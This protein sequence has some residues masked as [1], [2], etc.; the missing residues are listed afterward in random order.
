MKTEKSDRMLELLCFVAYC[1]DFPTRL[2]KRIGGHPDWT[3]HVMYDAVRNGYVIRRSWR[4]N[5]KVHTLLRITDKGLEYIAKRD[6][7][8]AAMLIAR[9]KNEPRVHMDVEKAARAYAVAAGL[10]MAYKAGAIIHPR[11]KPSLLISDWPPKAKPDPDCSYYYSIRE[12]RDSI[13]E[14][15]KE[16]VAKTSHLVGVIVHGNRCY[17]LYYTGGKRMYW[18]A[19][20]ELNAVSAVELMLRLR[21][22]ECNTVCQVLIGTSM[23]VAEWITRAGFQSRGPYFKLDTR[24]N[25]CYFVTD[26]AAGDDLLRVITFGDLQESFGKTVLA[27]TCRPPDI[28]TRAYDAV[29]SDGR[30]P[31]ILNYQCDLLARAQTDYAPPGF[32]ESPILYC[33]DY[34]MGTVQ[35]ILGG[36]IEVRAIEAPLPT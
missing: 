31:V 5:R 25:N 17:C 36:M 28:P 24:F 7:E 15:D 34:Q 8:N 11:M 6:P 20:T 1:G 21:G 32:R 3:R 4:N 14:Y 33:L 2:A 26:D 27:D 10:V 35:R 12:I 23:R 18:R 9:H 29:T 13:Q 22:F 16:T 19:P 30:R